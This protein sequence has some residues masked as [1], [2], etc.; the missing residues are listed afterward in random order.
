MC[1]RRL[2]SLKK[3]DVVVQVVVLAECQKIQSQVNFFF[4]ANKPL[5]PDS[6]IINRVN[7]TYTY[8]DALRTPLI[9]VN[10]YLASTEMLK[11]N[12]HS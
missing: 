10:H 8:I 1:I 5:K 4:S 12:E 11:V 3:P 6:I 9:C 7:T 2:G